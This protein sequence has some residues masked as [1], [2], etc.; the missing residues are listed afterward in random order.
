MSSADIRVVDLATAFASF[1]E[2]WSPRIAGDVN[3]SQ[4]RLAKL[5]G[6]FVWHRHEGRM[7]CSSS[8]RAACGCGFATART[9]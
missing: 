2:H 5:M 3:D 6:E 1:S 9:H 8:S 4:V 7:S